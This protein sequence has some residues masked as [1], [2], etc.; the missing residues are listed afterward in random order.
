MLWGDEFDGTLTC[1]WRKV[2]DLESITSSR[3]KERIHVVDSYITALEL[4]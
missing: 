1:R 3:D 2:C 4:P